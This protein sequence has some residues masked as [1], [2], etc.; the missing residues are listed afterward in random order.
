MEIRCTINSANSPGVVELNC[1]VDECDREVTHTHIIEF[2]NNQKIQSMV[3]SIHAFLIRT[4]QVQYNSVE[5][6]K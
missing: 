2:E 1:S 5:D 6:T 4:S 3:C